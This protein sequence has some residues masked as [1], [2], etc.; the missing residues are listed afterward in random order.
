MKNTELRS[1]RSARS[2]ILNEAWIEDWRLE[3]E[4]WQRQIARLNRRLREASG[5][6]MPTQK[7]APPTLETV[8]LLVDEVREYSDRFNK[9]RR[10]LGRLRRGSG[11]Y[12][13]VLADLDVEL[14][15]LKLK[16]EHAHD[17]LEKFEDSLPDE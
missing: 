2:L 10:K 7:A 6:Q 12:L 13:D 1:T 11:P 15:A 14:F 16:A 3:I 4:V 9:L 8:E 5:E 17:A